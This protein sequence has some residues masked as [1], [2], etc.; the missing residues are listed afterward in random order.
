MS[1]IRVKSQDLFR[2][3]VNDKGE[4]VEFDLS[5]VSLN[6]RCY[7]AIDKINNIIKEASEKEKQIFAKIVEEDIEDYDTE[8]KREYAKLQNDTFAKMREAMDYFLGDGACQKIFGD[9][10]N[11]DMFDLLIEEFEKPREELDGKSYFDKMQIT[12][13]NLQQRLMQKYNKNKKAVI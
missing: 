2:I 6:F 12:S 13:T 8:S 10:N 1:G 11:F 5:D 3:E 9:Y 7:E 4:Y